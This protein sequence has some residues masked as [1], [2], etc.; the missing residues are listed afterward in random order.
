VIEVIA[1]AGVA[2]GTLLGALY[3]I[4]L[5]TA[6][7]A[8]AADPVERRSAWWG[9]G[10]AVLII[11]AGASYLAT[12]AKHDV[13]AWI[14]RSAMIVVV[15]ITIVLWLRARIRGKPAGPDR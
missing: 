15:G 2:L 4:E 1:W 7:S 8:A 10:S 11:A 13:L 14:A 12:G 3:V 6:T 5:T 9:L